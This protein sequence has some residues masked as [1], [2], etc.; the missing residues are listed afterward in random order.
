M[1]EVLGVGRGVQAGKVGIPVDATGTRLLRARTS[2][3]VQV[4]LR[5]TTYKPRDEWVNAGKQ[6]SKNLYI[7]SRKALSSIYHSP[8]RYYF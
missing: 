4:R 5:N 1:R 3:Q 8:A 6:S 7:L 2:L